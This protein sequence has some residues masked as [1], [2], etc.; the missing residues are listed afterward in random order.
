MGGFLKVTEENNKDVMKKYALKEEYIFNE[1]VRKAVSHVYGIDSNIGNLII[2]EDS[3]RILE[4]MGVLD[5]WFEEVKEEYSIRY[6]GGTFN[7]RVE[8][9]NVLYEDAVIPL[10]DIVKI[11][12]I[13]NIGP[14]NISVNIG[15]KKEIVIEDLQQLLK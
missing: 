5:L 4:D 2:Y 11:L 1:N 12:N 3:V 6:S 8:G 15:C 13:N 9:D 7:V 10:K 14:W